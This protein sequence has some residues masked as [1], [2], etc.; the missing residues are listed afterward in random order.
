MPRHATVL[1]DRG[2][3]E[4]SV[5]SDPSG[6]SDVMGYGYGGHRVNAKASAP[7]PAVKGNN[8]PVLHSKTL[9]K[10]GGK[11][12]SGSPKPPPM[13]TRSPDGKLTPIRDRNIL[14]DRILEVSAQRLLWGGSLHH[15]SNNFIFRSRNNRRVKSSL[16]LPAD[17]RLAPLH[18]HPSIAN[19]LGARR[20]GITVRAPL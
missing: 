6:G 18:Q 9:N 2:S 8:R 7:S 1:K 3:A 15:Q 13:E 4:N 20:V 11:G 5:G 14:G 12:A 19:R 10:S 16:P 17:A